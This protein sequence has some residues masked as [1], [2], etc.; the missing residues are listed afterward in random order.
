MNRSTTTWLGRP[1]VSLILILLSSYGSVAAKAGG[2]SASTSA[3]VS[4]EYDDNPNLLTEGG[5]GVFG[6][7]SSP[8][9]SIRKVF[10]RSSINASA[11]LDINTFDGD[12]G[13]NGGGSLD[14]IDQHVTADMATR[15]RRSTIELG[16]SHDRESAR[17]SE[18]EDTGNL[19]EDATRMSFAGDARYSFQISRRNFI[20]V[21]G[22]AEDVSFDSG[23]L[24][25]FRSYGGGTG[26]RHV[27]SPIDQIG[28]S[29]NFSRFDPDSEEDT[30]SDILDVSA[31]W[32]RQVSPR[33]SFDIS[34]GGEA[35]RSDNPGSG[36]ETSFGFTLE[37]GLDW[38]PGRRDTI[39]ISFERS[40]QPSSTG[41]LQERNLV[42]A[43]YQRDLT[44]TVGFD[45]D[46]NFF[47]QEAA[48]DSGTAERT[49]FE[50]VPALSWNFHPDWSLLTSYRYRQQKFGSGGD[51]AT[52]NAFFLTI[53][54]SSPYVSLF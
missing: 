28:L 46:F 8:S 15:T 36:D 31:S 49:F 52:S 40:A 54:Y 24:T 13:Q 17:T 21:F 48:D 39:G 41:A 19:S 12:G 22:D 42:S 47:Q 44:R 33:L 14:S 35:I 20:D 5:T 38:K 10:P 30:P 2:W 45:L 53:S 9:V 25:G 51:S 37:G 3:D 50:V 32:T 27:L 4:G 6:V 26:F 34:L 29:A 7:T 11:G 1:I 43:T 23:N 16:F 18:I